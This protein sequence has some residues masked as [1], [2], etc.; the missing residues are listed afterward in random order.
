M[1]DYDMSLKRDLVHY[2]VYGKTMKFGRQSCLEN[3]FVTVYHRTIDNF[4]TRFLSSNNSS[5]LS[6]APSNY[7]VDTII[8]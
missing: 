3:I 4:L 8:M 6:R 7:T 1:N 2:R 5:V